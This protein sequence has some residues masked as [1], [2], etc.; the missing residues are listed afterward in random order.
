VILRLNQLKL[1]RIPIK[2]V[3]NYIPVHT[4]DHFDEAV[5]S[6]IIK[7]LYNTN[8]FADVQLDRV[9]DTLV[10][11]VTERSVIS[12]IQITGNRQ[13]K[14]EE[15]LKLFKEAGQGV[16]EVYDESAIHSIKQTLQS[17]YSQLSY[18][19]AQ[20]N[21]TPD[22]TPK[23]GL[24]VNVSISEGLSAKVKEI[25]I[26]GNTQFSSARLIRQLKLTT[27]RLW[28]FITKTDQFSQEKLDAS[29]EALKTFYMDKG[30]I[31]F[32]VNS[33]QAT[34]TPDRKSV[35]VVINITEGAR[36]HFSGFKFSGNL[37]V[38]KSKLTKLIKL[39]QGDIFSRKVLQDAVDALGVAIGDQG[40]AFAQIE[41][42]PE[43]DEQNKTVFINFF[44]SPGKQVYVRRIGFSGNA[45]TADYVLRHAVQQMEGGLI[46]VSKIRESVRQLNLLGYFKNVQVKS[47][48]VEGTSNQVDLGYSVQEVNAG[49]ISANFSYSTL[50]KFGIG[51]GINQPNFMGTGK[52]V[53]INFSRDTYIRS[54]GINYYNPYF[55][56]SGIGFGANVTFQ[57]TR[58]AAL[59]IS[60]YTLDNYGASFYYTIPIS[61]NDSLQLGYGFNKIHIGANTDPNAG[62]VVP[63]E[64]LNFI[65]RHGS[66][67]EQVL[68]DAS[69]NHNSQDKSIFPTQGLQTSLAAE[70][71]VP[72]GHSLNYYKL[73]AAFNYLIPLERSHQ[74]VLSLKGGTGYGNGYGEQKGLPFFANYYAGG[75]SQ[76]EVRGIESASL[77]PR[78]SNNQSIGGN[79]LVYGSAALIFPNYL[80]DSFR[81]SVF[82]DA[83]NVYQ[84]NAYLKSF[85]ATEAGKLRYSAGLAVTWHSPVGLISVSLGHLLNRQAQDQSQ[86]FQFTMGTTI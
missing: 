22:A 18:Y 6:Q 48:P 84:T 75:L 32:Q 53:G 49:S 39:R 15:L 64:I 83:G 47:T 2:T 77:G 23:S 28:T 79:F 74:W 27:P 36:Y 55:T 60:E 40:Y 63:T 72:V 9:G 81:T 13:I 59:N 66:N 26:I 8:F 4:G 67:F 41:P 50:T 14:K 73:G 31:H 86:V 11:A 35:R 42:I 71:S 19:N 51:A 20:V 58:P 38:E 85:D 65:N 62:R 12:R 5:S 82:L 56:N 7:S 68:L 43:I 25:D 1:N 61:L 30:Y 54:Y 16:G 78:D 24:T 37:I 33:A 70:V 52:T 34:L 46:S 69:W 44:V 29:T 80:S 45:I 21:I 57:K 10:V 3:L 76:G 17:Q